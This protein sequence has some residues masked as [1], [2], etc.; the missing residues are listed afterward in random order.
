MHYYDSHIHTVFSHDGRQTMRDACEAA[1]KNG[2]SGIAIT[3][4]ADPWVFEDDMTAKCIAASV[5]S[6]AA[7]AEYYRDRPKVFR[8]VELGEP[9]HDSKI[10]EFMLKNYDYDIVIG[11]IHM[12]V[13]EDLN[14]AYSGIDFSPD[15]MSDEKLAGYLG[16]YFEELYKMAKYADYDVLAHLDCPRRYI[17]GK[18]H[19]GVSLDAYYD[20]IDAILTEVINRGK[21]LELNSSGIGE[22]YGQFMP[23]G[24]ILA[25][26]ADL[27]GTMITLGSDAHREGRVGAGLKEAAELAAAHGFDR[28][29]YYENRTPMS[30]AID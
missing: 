19:R 16:A 24:D 30:V 15:N 29:Y 28:Y 6:A 3:D 26:Y 8:G 23:N 14:I 5:G 25:R 12:L 13:Y 4:H 18:Y 20:V 2:I 11:S 1:I 22:Y 21:S 9:F 27:G 10:T 17:N 7:S